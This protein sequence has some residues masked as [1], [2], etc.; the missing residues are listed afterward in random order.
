MNRKIGQFLGEMLDLDIKKLYN[1]ET[2]IIHQ[3]SFKLQII[4]I[5]S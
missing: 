4:N 1:K 2:I 5:I 3:M